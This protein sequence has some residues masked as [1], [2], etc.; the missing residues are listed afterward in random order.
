MPIAFL[1]F[2]YMGSH[3]SS[4]TERHFALAIIGELSAIA[5]GVRLIVKVIRQGF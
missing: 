5:M 3:S 2:A 1:Y 4:H